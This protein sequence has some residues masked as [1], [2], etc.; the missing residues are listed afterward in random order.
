MCTDFATECKLL[1]DYKQSMDKT[2]PVVMTSQ[3]VFNPD[4]GVQ[5]IP[6]VAIIGPDGKVAYNGLH[7]AGDKGEKIEKINGLLKKAGLKHP[8]SLAEAE[9][10]QQG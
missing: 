9:A 3:D 1:A 10:N 7:P 6:H 4:F 8:P 2:W 5:G